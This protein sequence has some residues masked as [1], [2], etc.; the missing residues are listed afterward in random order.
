[1]SY[2]TPWQ[3]NMNGGALSPLMMGRVKQDVWGVS[4]E[5]C[6]GFLPLLQG[7]LEACPGFLFVSKMAAMD[8][9]PIPFAFNATQHYVIEAT[10]GK[11]RFYTNDVR[12]E[13]APGVPFEVVTPYTLAQV[14]ALN[15]CQS[16]DELY[17]YHR[18]VPTRKLARTG[19][20]SF[21]LELWEPR[22]GPWDSRNQDEALTVL[23]SGTTGAI[24]LT[25]A[26]PLFAAGDVGGLFEIEFGDLAAIPAWDA[27]I[28]ITAGALRQWDGNVY[29][30]VSGAR[31]GTLAPA[32][33]SGTEWDGSGSGSDINNKGPYGAQWL[34]LH[35]R[36]GQV[37]IDGYTSSTQV[38]ATVQKRLAS[39]GTAQYRWKFG[40]FS[41][42][43][44]YP[45]VGALIE[46]QRHAV[47]KDFT[48]YGSVAGG[49]DD[50]A[51]RADSGEVTR[52]M[53]FTVPLPDPNPVRWIVWANELLVGT[54]NAEYIIRQSSAAAGF[55]P[56]NAVPFLETE[57]GSAVAQPVRVD[58]RTLFIW[59]E[60][61]KIGQFG[62][63][64]VRDGYRTEDLNRFADHMGND[65]FAEIA[66]AGAPKRLLWARTEAGELRACLYVPDEQALGWVER[67]LADG[68]FCTGVTAIT[69]PDGR[70]SQ[71]WVTV[72]VG[73]EGWMLRLAPIRRTGDAS[74]NQV[75]SDAAIVQAGAV[76]TAI[77]APHLAGRSVEV[78][79][80]GRLHPPV[81]L[82]GAGNGALNFAAATKIFGLPFEAE[83]VTLPME[84][85]ADNGVAQTKR[86]RLSQAGLR[87]LN[88]HG[89]TM[90][91]QGLGFRP[92]ENQTA[93]SPLDIAFPLITK[94]WIVAAGGTY[95]AK[96]QIHVKRTAPKPSTILAILA[97][98]ETGAAS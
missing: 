35:D 72:R 60:R 43:R 97:H 51:T 34:Y 62:R 13:T 7:P 48:V 24:T 81:L 25:S 86:K 95:E 75:M 27:G 74:L 70:D 76:S 19:A 11:F 23:A 28:T 80:D 37:K 9:R 31:T 85:G 78:V 4:L 41:P 94:D 82:D 38:N 55:G 1:M 12:I 21:V 47:A 26:Q 45:M 52:D 90:S 50:F 32:H 42:R 66:W 77:S 29:Q 87:L 30:C 17:L 79:V 39:S 71:L 83:F 8:G 53:A 15:W 92:L 3:D 36:W 89:L 33:K 46:D 16:G 96:G 84:A 64:E 69:D 88:S 73:S 91:V 44:G 22:N 58:G 20:E 10:A 98:A 65:G 68:L 61:G 57:I 14:M 56:G 93:T 18:D 67:P 54:A 2:V 40:A 5:S 6:K 49:F 63:A 59:A